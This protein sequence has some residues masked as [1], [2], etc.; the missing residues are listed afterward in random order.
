MK[1]Y[2]IDNYKGVAE[3]YIFEPVFDCSAAQFA[4]D[5]KGIVEDEVVIRINSPGGSLFDAITIYNVLRDCKKRIVT[6]IDGIAASAASIIFLAGDER[7]MPENTSMLIHNPLTGAYGDEVELLK[8]ANWL[9]KWKEHLV[10]IYKSNSNLSEGNIKEMMSK[11]TLFSAR[12]AYEIGFATKITKP[13]VVDAKWIDN[14]INK[15]NEG[16]ED[17][18]GK[19][20]LKELERKLKER[21]DQLASANEALEK[22][23]K[24]RARIEIEAR[25]DKDIAAKKLLPKARNVAVKM[26]EI[27]EAD[28]LEFLEAYEIPN[29]EELEVKQSV[30]SA[31]DVTFADLLNDS[32]ALEKMRVEDPKQYLKLY[33]E[34]VG[35]QY[36]N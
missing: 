23:R 8:T 27:S 20:E 13:V 28:Y 5:L 31:K 34:Y 15:Q 21:E 11:E 10:H 33:N 17:T 32:E 35:G 7:I 1:F 18:E 24:D 4:E 2:S 19:M 29:L 25:V 26:L 3:I 30:Q 12:E 36:G 6:K 16:N 22:E 14:I 9:S